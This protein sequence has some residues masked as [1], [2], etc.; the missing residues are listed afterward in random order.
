[1]KNVPEEAVI[2]AADAMYEHSLLSGTDPGGKIL[3]WMSEAH[4]YRAV[5]RVALTAALPHLQRG[6]RSTIYSMLKWVRAKFIAAS[7]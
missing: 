4:E 7:R 5:A 1:M 3:Q 2:A 6:R